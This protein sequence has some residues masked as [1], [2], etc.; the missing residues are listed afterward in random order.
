[1]RGRFGHNDNPSCL[2]FKY[3]LRRILLHNAIKLTTG[4]CSLMTPVEDS[5]FAFKWNTKKTNPTI[6]EDIDKDIQLFAENINNTINNGQRAFQNITDNV[7]YYIC[8][9][10][11]KKLTPQFKCEYCI[12]TLTNNLP[13]PDH[14][15]CNQVKVNSFKTF[16][17]LKNRG[18]LQ[19]SSENVFKIIKLTEKYF[20][21]LLVD[22]KQL[23]LPRI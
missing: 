2:Q 11:V 7:L 20:K 23:L 12:D 6:H 15:Y 9:Y 17:N 10:V 21:S 16:T 5:L 3:A 13:K 19:L 4:N 14:T 1:M 18:G 22:K 8:G